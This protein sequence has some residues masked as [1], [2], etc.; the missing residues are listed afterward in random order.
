M[1]FNA[2]GPDGLPAVFTANAAG[3]T[4]PAQRR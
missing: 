3:L 4:I 2:V 1:T